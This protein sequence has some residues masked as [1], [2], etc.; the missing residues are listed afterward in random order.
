MHIIVFC[1]D[2]DHVVVSSSSSRC[3][4]SIR[5]RCAVVPLAVVLLFPTLLMI[6]DSEMVELI[7]ILMIKKYYMQIKLFIFQTDTFHIV[8]SF[9]VFILFSF[10]IIT[11]N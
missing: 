1:A 6:C 2:D 3:R 10:V 8:L 9:S 5:H 4:H 7:L 11:L